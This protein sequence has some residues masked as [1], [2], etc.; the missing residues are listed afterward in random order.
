MHTIRDTPKNTTGLC[1][2]SHANE[3]ALI[4]Y[5]GS[6]Q[7]GEVQVFD[8]MNLRA[9]SGITAH[10]SPLA[11][12]DFNSTGTKLATASTTVVILVYY[13]TPDLLRVQ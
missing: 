2:L 3:T 5:P 12:L 1:G 11:A 13:L 10:D 7:T 4:A 6:S 8:A 9:V